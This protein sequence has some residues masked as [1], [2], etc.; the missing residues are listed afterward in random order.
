MTAAGACAT[1]ECPPVLAL[2]PGEPLPPLPPPWTLAT[3]DWTWVVSV[4]A[5]Q[6]AHVAAAATA[7]PGGHWRL[8][9]TGS[10][11]GAGDVGAGPREGGAQGGEDAA[12]AM[13]VAASRRRH[14]DFVL[15]AASWAVS[16]DLDG[17]LADRL[18]A[19]AGPGG[20]RAA[21]A[22]HVDPGGTV[23]AVVVAA[24]GAALAAGILAAAQP[25]PLG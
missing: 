19:L 5:A 16:P 18:G 13:D 11:T 2:Q 9:V 4:A 3:G 7:L 22:V 20:G 1:E 23:Q 24:A 6:V 25:S 21:M 8:G 12:A 10:T 14:G 15:A 17:A